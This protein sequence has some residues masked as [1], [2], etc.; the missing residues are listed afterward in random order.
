M[1]ALQTSRRQACCGLPLQCAS[2]EL[3]GAGIAWTSVHPADYHQ[4]SF[5][6]GMCRHR[7]ITFCRDVA[8]HPVSLMAM[9]TLT[10]SVTLSVKAG[11]TEGVQ[12]VLL[13]ST[14]RP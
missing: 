14:E 11:L 7:S 5:A 10:L 3:L 8:S 9:M 4:I 6:E 1:N 13:R 12:Q 2:R